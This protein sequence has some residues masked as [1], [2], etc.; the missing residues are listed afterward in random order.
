MS[1]RNCILALTGILVAGLLFFAGC[2]TPEEIAEVASARA[3]ARAAV[4]ERTADSPMAAAVPGSIVT[5]KSTT[6]SVQ[7]AQEEAEASAVPEQAP[8]TSAASAQVPAA[9]ASQEPAGTPAVPLTPA[10]TEPQPTEDPAASAGTAPDPYARVAV[11]TDFEMLRLGSEGPLVERLHLYLS[12]LGYLPA[13]SGSHFGPETEDA[14][15]ALQKR[16][17]LDADGIVGNSTWD[18]LLMSNAR[19]AA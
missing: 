6:G 16:N 14:V 5:L 8:D 19:P 15:I 4:E 12:E 9:P 3:S 13:A 10:Q 2:Q 1:K 17:S 11:G 7:R 18:L